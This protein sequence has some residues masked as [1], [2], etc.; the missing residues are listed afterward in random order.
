MTDTQPERRKR[1]TDTV[2]IREHPETKTAMMYHLPTDVVL[3]KWAA[4][5]GLEE[6]AW[7]AVCEYAERVVEMQAIDWDTDDADFLFPVNNFEKRYMDPVGFGE[8]TAEDVSAEI[9]EKL[10]RR[11]NKK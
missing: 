11:F 2:E 5:V 3:K 9:M 10:M 4:V 6:G 8:K 7:S 1:I